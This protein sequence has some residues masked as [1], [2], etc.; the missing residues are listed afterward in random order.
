MWIKVFVDYLRFER[1]LSEKTIEAYQA[2]LEAFKQFYKNLNS[3]LSWKTVDSDIVRDW[4]VSMMDNGNSASSVNRRLSALRSFYRFL[5][6]RKMVT[7]D[8]V[9]NLQGPKKEKALPYYIRESE[10]NK[11]LDGEGYFTEDFEGQR[12]K[13]ILLMFYST[14]IRLSELTGLNLADVDLDQMQ[15]KVTGKRN[16]QR[17]IP[18]GDEMGDAIRSYLDVRSSF[19]ASMGKA[20]EELS[21]FLD[22]RIGNRILPSKVQALVKKYLSLVTTQRKRSPH[23]LRHSFATSM[24]NHH[25]D[26]QSVKELLGH[27]SLST[28]EIY[29]HTSFEELKE[30]YNQA[31]PRAK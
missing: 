22:A 12:D 8:P 6:R 10:M 2:D 25:A 17:I 21:F 18:Y 9:H 19:L 29:T 31:H 3:E 5:L 16:K 27:E 7:V 20:G 14:G 26:L 15:V 30:M 4:E 1:N 11:L 23:V 13:M 28:T 24:L